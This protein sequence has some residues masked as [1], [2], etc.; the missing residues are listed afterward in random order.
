MRDQYAGDISDLLKFALLRA[1]ATDDRSLGV[2]WY[3][4]PAHDGRPDGRH[5]DYLNNPKWR[6]LDPVLIEALHRLNCPPSVSAIQALPIWPAESWFHDV[7][8]PP[9]HQRTEWTDNMRRAMNRADIVFLDPDNGIGSAGP[10]HATCEEIALLRR[11]GRAIVVIRFPGR[12]G[13]HVEQLT[14][15]LRM[16]RHETGA[17][18]ILTLTTSVQVGIEH[19][20]TVPRTRWFTIIDPDDILIARA[21]AF[22]CKLNKIGKCQISI[23]LANKNMSMLSKTPRDAIL[24]LMGILEKA[25]ATR[26]S[27]ET[28]R[29]QP[30]A[31]RAVFS[32]F[33]GIGQA[34]GARN[35]I[36]HGEIVPD[37]S[38]ARAILDQ[39]LSEVPHPPLR[40]QT[41]KSGP[42]CE[43]SSSEASTAG[44]APARSIPRCKWVY[45]AT[46][47]VEDFAATKRLVTSIGLIVRTVYNGADIAIANTRQIR[48]G[49][50]VLLVHGGGDKG[51]PYRP[52]LSCEVIGSPRP[53]QGFSGF[54]FPEDRHVSQL[55][56]SGYRR[57]PHFG[58]YTG[59]AIKPL[60]DLEGISETIP[61]P[62][63][64]NT[65]RKWEEIF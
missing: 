36:A 17:A 54:S 5:R 53:I 34:C 4:N 9:R 13:K 24:R 14:T 65:I 37:T 18:A 45:F 28:F 7:P 6:D 47:S 23:D 21:G 11:S 52:M 19:G 55:E 31:N 58:R 22:A 63:G 27:S 3:Y 33:A 50:S 41:S 56:N 62:R 57:D 35:L 12:R 2:C 64:N 40:S 42:F 20:R 60:I 15:W 59:I 16:L 25:P 43:Q 39:T 8:I 51:L 44:A 32:N 29:E 48:V 1:L 38:E 10:R 49:D 61:R 26:T 30:D 46:D